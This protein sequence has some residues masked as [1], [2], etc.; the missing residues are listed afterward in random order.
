MRFILASKS[1]RRM[2]LLT[3]M[4]IQFLV[5]PADGEEIISTADPVQAVCNLSYQKAFE[6]GTKRKEEDVIVI[7]ADTVVAVN[8]LILG[9]PKDEEDAFYM[10]SML[11]GNE[12]SV[13]TGVTLWSYSASE[14]MTHTFYEE[15]KVKMYPMTESE[16]RAY[17]ATGEPMD[18]AGA[19]GIQGKC[20]V[21][22]QKINGDYNNV[23]GLPI[24][25]LYQN[26]MKIGID[27][28]KIS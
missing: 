6:V 25:S 22:I 2:E 27:I 8:G 3:Q 18:K 10:L 15:T 23:V 14:S 9:K 17:I 24:A 28:Y 7:G 4:G 5:V 26:L 12:H 1:P 21:F 19:Y 13:Y 20:A 16:I 11:Q